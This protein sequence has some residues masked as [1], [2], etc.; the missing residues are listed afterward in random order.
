VVEFEV[1]SATDL[2]ENVDVA[3]NRRRSRQFID[4]VNS[5]EAV[6]LADWEVGLVASEWYDE[7]PLIELRNV[8]NLT[9]SVGSERGGWGNSDAGVK[10]NGESSLM[11]R[12]LGELQHELDGTSVKVELLSEVGKR[13]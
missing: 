1:R 9:M 6:G 7:G 2:C 13:A 5:Y 3:S 10:H 8:N 11:D 12:G 4:H